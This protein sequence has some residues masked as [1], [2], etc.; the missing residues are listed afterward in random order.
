MYQAPRGTSD[1]LPKEQAYWRFIEQ[2]VT[3]VCQLYGYER[4]DTPVFE[5]TQ[6]FDRSVGEGTDIV[7][8]EMYTFEDRGKNK[9]TLRPEGTAPVCRAYLEQGLHNLPQPVKLYYAAS[10]F[11]YERPQ[12][13]RY[14]QHYQFGYEAIGEDDPA[15]DTEVIDMAWQF[16][17]SLN[18]QHL[19]LQLNSI[20]CKKCRPGY[21]GVLK[22]YYANYTHDLCSNCKTRLKRNPLR[23]LDC[24]NEK[25]QQ[26]ANLASRSIDYLCPQCDE[27]FNQLKRYLELLGLPFVINHCLVRGLDYYT[28]TVFEIQPESEGAQATL[29]GGGRYDDLIEELGGKPTPAIGFAAGIERIILNL[30]KQNIPIPSLPKPQIFIAYVGDEAKDRA[31]KLATTLRQNGTGVIEAIG[32]KSLKSQL[33]QANTLGTRYSVIIGEQ[34]VKTDT[35]ILRDMI[36]AQQKTIPISQLQMTL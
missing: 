27:H 11:R 9:I 32:N 34:E 15:L 24:K 30:K 8:K 4:I 22:N 7:E 18:L 17:L 21:L 13:G 2:K 1:I 20:G 16:F 3:N 26:V 33:R 23:L 10:I 25:C 36:T 14:R 19:S 5:D 35:V 28:K 12:A 29:G 31:I 6:L